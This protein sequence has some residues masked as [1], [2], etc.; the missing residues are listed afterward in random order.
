LAKRLSLPHPTALLISVSYFDQV[1]AS[2]CCD[3]TGKVHNRS[4]HQRLKAIRAILFGQ[5]AAA[6]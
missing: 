5:D 6:S 4:R 1:L 3:K 2:D